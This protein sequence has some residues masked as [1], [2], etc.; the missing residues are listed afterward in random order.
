MY[1]K[2]RENYAE[3]H[4][5]LFYIADVIYRAIYVGKKW[6]QQKLNKKR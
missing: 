3:L 1:S 4:N 5:S 6:Q 2:W